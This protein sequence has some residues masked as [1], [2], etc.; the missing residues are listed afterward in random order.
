MKALVKFSKENKGLFTEE[1]FDKVQARLVEPIKTTYRG[2]E[3]YQNAPNSQGITNLM[4]LNILEGYDLKK[5]GRNNAETIHLVAEAIKLAFADRHWYVGDP[6]WVKVP[7][8]KLLSKDYAA[9]QRK[10]IDMNKAQTWPIQGGLE[11]FTKNTT[12]I[13][14]KDASGNAMSV[15]TSIGSNWIV[16]GDTGI[17]INNRMPMFDLDDGLPNQVQPGKKIRHTS[18]PCMAFKDGKLYLLWACSGVDTQPQ[19]QVQALV[20]VVDFGMNPLEAVSAPR[21]IQHSFPVTRV[22]RASDILALERDRFSPE[23]ID[24]LKKKGHTIGFNAIFGNMNMIM[25]DPKTGG[26]LGGVDPR[27]EGYAVGW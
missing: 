11:Q 9:A 21:F 3:V 25:V 16:M 18:N 27:Q 26:L 4:A 13:L 20:N 19:V 15:T 12:T 5:M 10:R 17:M 24:A 22:R 6:D 8:D 2:V 23:I 14:V 7:T 1:D